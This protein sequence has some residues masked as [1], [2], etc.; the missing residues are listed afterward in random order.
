MDPDANVIDASL[1]FAR[2]NPE[3]L[4]YARAAAA[5][6]GRGVDDLLQDAIDRVSAQLQRRHGGAHPTASRRRVGAM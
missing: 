3:L 4:A 6:T 1:R 2:S 5:Q